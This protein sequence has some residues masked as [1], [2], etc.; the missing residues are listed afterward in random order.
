MHIWLIPKTPNQGSG[1][2]VHQKIARESDKWI[3]WVNSDDINSRVAKRQTGNLMKAC[4]NMK[5]R[6]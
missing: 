6:K 1:G 2:T 5:T 4:R 3:R